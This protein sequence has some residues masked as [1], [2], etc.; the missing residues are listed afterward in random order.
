M[1]ISTKGRYGVRFM[2]DLVAH[3]GEGNV[4]LKKVAERQAISEKYL[5]QIVNPLRK[6]GLIRAVAGPGGGYALAQSAASI[7]LRDILAVLEGSDMPAACVVDPSG[8]P[9]GNE[10]AAREMWCE[11]G[12]RIGEVLNS[13]TLRD[14]ADRQRALTGSPPWDYAI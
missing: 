8:G 13:I 2:M 5:W 7:T 4:T 1:R 14:L 12:A 6:E 9:R 10:C 11:V 3:E